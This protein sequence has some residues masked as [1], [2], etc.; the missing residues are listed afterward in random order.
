MNQS[1]IRSLSAFDRNLE[2][3]VAEKLSFAEGGTAAT[4]P[5]ENFASLASPARSESDELSPDLLLDAHGK[6][7]RTLNVRKG[8]DI[9][10]CGSH[11]HWLYV[12]RS[13]WLARYKILHNGSKSEERRVGKE[14]RSRQSR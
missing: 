11:Y 7:F 5:A 13:G 6:G 14:C 8:K 3:S 1:K 2:P 10:I 4:A 9:M 12:N